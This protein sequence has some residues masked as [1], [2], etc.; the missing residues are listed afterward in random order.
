MYF[1]LGPAYVFYFLFNCWQIISPWC[2]VCNFRNI[3]CI[4]LAYVFY[5]VVNFWQKICPRCIVY[6]ISDFQNIF[7]LGLPGWEK[8]YTGWPNNRLLGIKIHLIYVVIYNL[9]CNLLLIIDSY[10]KWL[11][12]ICNIPSCIGDLIW[13]VFCLARHVSFEKTGVMHR[14]SQLI[15]VVLFCDRECPTG[16][17]L[18]TANFNDLNVLWPNWFAS[19]SLCL[20]NTV[21]KV[22]D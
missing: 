13:D 12:N 7:F 14:L 6:N 22:V 16:G 9:R 1:S 19:C 4:G 18:Q 8:Q 17:S 15:R 11:S 3:V 21:R 10:S 5:F 20:N 2:N